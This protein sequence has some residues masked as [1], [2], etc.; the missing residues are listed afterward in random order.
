[1]NFE[2][3][4][5]LLRT[6]YT[7]MLPLCNELS[8]VAKGIAG[9][10]AL[11][12]VAYRIWQTLARAEPIDVF[13]LLRPIVIGTCIIF[14]QTLV[15]SPINGIMSP[16]VQGCANML[17]KQQQD[18]SSTKERRDRLEREAML[19]DPEKAYLIDNEIYDKRMKELGML[20]AIEKSNMFLQREIYQFKKGI[21][22]GFKTV[23]E[24][25]YNGAALIIDV[26][27]TFFLIILVIMGPIAFAISVWDGFQA[28]LVQW[29]TRYVGIY[30]WLPVSDI[31]SSIM[32]RIHLLILQ[33]DIKTFEN[34][35]YTGDGSN[36]L[37]IVFLLIGIIG[38][39]TVPTVS[40]WIIESGGGGNYSR[41]I[42]SATT[43]LGAGVAGFSGAALGSAVRGIPGL[44]KGVSNGI[45]SGGRSL[46]NRFTNNETGSDSTNTNQ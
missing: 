7:E 36:L 8:G 9:L 10:G 11:F 40:S 21:Q 41:A 38:Y 44:F 2:N 20:D 42:N 16:I 35:E 37:Y 29:I 25:I 24:T 18:V 19:R 1:M 5:Q 30:L 31:F 45:S 43:K 17:G 23:L 6:L 14:F 12:Y 33:N 22:D 15:I 46:L 4:H 32:A 3:M 27:R 28:T 13:P 39:F 26:I 34:P